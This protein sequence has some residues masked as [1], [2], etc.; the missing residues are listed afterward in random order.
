MLSRE[1]SLFAH[2]ASLSLGGDRTDYCGT[3]SCRLSRAYQLA[4]FASLYSDRVYIRSFLLKYL[5]QTLK[6]YRGFED[7]LKVRLVEDLTVISELRPLISKGVIVPFSPPTTYCPCCLAK[8]YLGNEFEAPFETAYER[9]KQ[10]YLNKVSYVL[11]STKDTYRL[12]KRGP[13]T[14]IDHKLTA[15]SYVELPP[16]YQQFPDVIKN[17]KSKAGA[18]LSREEVSRLNLHKNEADRVVESIAFE[19]TAAQTLHTSFLTDRSLH[20]DFLNSLN[21]NPAVERR[22]RI[23]QK[24]LTCFVPFL[25][26]VSLKDLMVLREQEQEAFVAYRRE[27]K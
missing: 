1:V 18:T 7:I 11:K 17:A 15:F 13:E 27:L 16:V 14:L 23:A 10:D 20:L 5:P 12:H 3:L 9:L 6:A 19:L 4:Q 25:D 2:S 26:G 21:Q 22:N 8:L 24:Y